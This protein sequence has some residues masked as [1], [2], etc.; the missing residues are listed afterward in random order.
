[1]GELRS[2]AGN[3]EAAQRWARAVNHY[4]LWAVGAKERGSVIPSQQVW[5]PGGSWHQGKAVH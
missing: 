5:S 1:M 2:Q 3:G 4:Q